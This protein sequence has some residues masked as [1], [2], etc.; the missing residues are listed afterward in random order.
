[1]Y[2][3][4]IMDT[5]VNIDR[6]Q[7]AIKD[8]IKSHPIE[9]QA[10]LIHL[11]KEQYGIATN[12]AAISRDL[13]ALGIYKRARGNRMVY[14]LLE[15]DAVIEILH[16]AIK[17]AQH[18][19]AIIIIKTIPGTASLVADYIDTQADLAILGTIAGENMVFVAPQSIKS[20]EAVFNQLCQQLKIRRG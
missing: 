10:D 20:I 11:L 12:Q 2:G 8:L 18:N 16:Y 15:T 14:E 7:E 6:R 5:K 1:M 3:E 13:R 9:D 4:K 17:Y 19:E